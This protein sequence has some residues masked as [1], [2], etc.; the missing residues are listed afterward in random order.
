M[1]AAFE[2]AEPDPTPR[3]P[4]QKRPRAGTPRTPA[5]APPVEGARPKPKSS[6]Q[7]EVGKGKSEYE[8][9]RER[10]VRQATRLS[11][12]HLPHSASLPPCLP[13]CLPASPPPPP[14]PPPPLLLLLPL[15][16]E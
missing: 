15:L 13:P 11:P 16:K 10:T 12:F 14:P 9:A 2:K 6:M 4:S 7:S 3:L 1:I 5:A 8:L